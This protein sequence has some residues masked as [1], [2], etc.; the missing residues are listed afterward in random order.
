M[1]LSFHRQKWQS[2]LKGKE[3]LFFSSTQYVL[4]LEVSAAWN[5]VLLWVL[6]DE[7]ACC[8]FSLIWLYFCCLS[9]PNTLTC[10]LDTFAK[11][12]DLTSMLAIM[13]Y[14]NTIWTFDSLRWL[15]ISAFYS[16]SVRWN[17]GATILSSPYSSN[18][19]LDG[20]FW[21]CSNYLVLLCRSYPV[22]KITATS[23]KS[24]PHS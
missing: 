6:T 16:V 8:C 9:F 10:I 1:S 5:G 21:N 22:C 4:Y 13:D 23:D 3:R 7:S 17:G 24:T 11:V 2:Q 14:I 12:Q 20:S 15:L 19:F 18:V